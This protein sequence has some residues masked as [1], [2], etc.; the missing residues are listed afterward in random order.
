MRFFH[1]LSVD[2][3]NLSLKGKLFSSIA[4]FCS[5]FFIALTT[6]A[7]SLNPEYPIIVAS[8]GASA[9]I[10]FFIPNSP[11]AQPWPFVGGQLCSALIGVS[12]A[13]NITELASAASVAVGG[14]IIAMLLL[15]CLH[16]PG[17]ATSL[18]PVMAGDSIISQ[19]YHFVLQPVAINVAIMLFLVIFINRWVMKL[20]YPTPIKTNDEGDNNSENTPTNKARFIIK[21]EDVEDAIKSLDVFVDIS[22]NELK[23][24]LNQ[25][26]LTAFK[27]I[28]K[29]ILCRDIMRTNID[30][31]LYGTEVETAWDILYNQRLKA[32]PVVDHSQRVIGIITWYDFIKFLNLTPYESFQERFRQFIR[33]TTGLETNKPEYVGHLM[34]TSV[35][36]IQ[37]TAHIADLIPLMTSEAFRHIPVIDEEHRLKGIIYQADMISAIYE[38]TLAQNIENKMN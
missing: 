13:L 10:L 30:Y 18:A 1:F 17:A 37:E 16:P 29:N 24:I 2:P 26:E 8:M 12:C 22:H 27:R 5:I 21:D 38:A 32:L 36:A 33:R 15:R 31:V 34:T 4:C 6:H 9:I 19:G 20:D 28:R 14:S 11:L 23:Q 25:L 35:K 7:F 3:V